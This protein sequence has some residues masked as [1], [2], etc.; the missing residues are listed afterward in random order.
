MAT[1]IIAIRKQ[2][3]KMTSTRGQCQ[4]DNLEFLAFPKKYF[5]LKSLE[6]SL[7]YTEIKQSLGKCQT[8]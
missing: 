4:C 5:P 2:P 7:E 1:E 3:Q 6:E 8:D